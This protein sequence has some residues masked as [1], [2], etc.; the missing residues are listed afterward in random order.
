M[1]T[2][3]YKLLLLATVVSALEAKNGQL[4]ERL[5]EQDGRMNARIDSV[6]T[7][8]QAVLSQ[9]NQ[10][11]HDENTKQVS[12]HATGLS[13]LT[14]SEGAVLFP[15]NVL[16]NQG[17]GYNPSTGKFTAPFNGTYCFL[18]TLWGD[19]VDHYIA[20]YLMVDGKQELFVETTFGRDGDSDAASLQAVVDARAGQSVWLQVLFDSNQFSPYP[21]SNSFSGFLV[22]YDP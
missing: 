8:A 16:N 7:L 5:M 14:P 4:K 13:N 9:L 22:S 3:L 15:T 21:V 10:H 17:N 11:L 20:V 6:E 2:S 19:G 12:F 1:G 18:A